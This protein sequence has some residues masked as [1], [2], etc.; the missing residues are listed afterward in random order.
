VIVS[1]TDFGTGVRVAGTTVTTTASFCTL[2][3][4][5]IPQ[6]WTGSASSCL[7]WP[8]A[9]FIRG[10]SF[11]TSQSTPGSAAGRKLLVTAKDVATG[12]TVSAYVTGGY[13]IG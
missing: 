8:G 1:V 5:G 6:G 13:T 2:S 12:V 4:G 7:A 3:P 10:G 9:V 11:S